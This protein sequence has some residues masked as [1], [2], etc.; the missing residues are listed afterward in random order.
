VPKTLAKPAFDVHPG[1][2]MVRKWADELPEKTGRSLAQ[3]AKFVA[4][5][6][7]PD[8]KDRIAFLKDQHHLGT[9]TAWQI[10]MYAEDK[11]TW[12]GDPKVYLK[13]ADQYVTDMFAGG[14]AGLKPIFDA[15]LIEGRKLGTDVKVC[16]CK[17]IVP[18]YRERVFAE[19]K[20]ATKT[21]LEFSLALGDEPFAGRLVPN[22]RAKGNDRLRHQFHLA[23]VADIDGEVLRWLQAAYDR[24]A[25]ESRTE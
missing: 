21:R 14:K 16:P 25:A 19:I 18:F 1:V 15:L 5:C 24:D 7:I 4:G 12:D 22:P 23:S 3:W 6:G 10:V 9:N 2:A 20:P 17:T 11:A 13:N 8:R